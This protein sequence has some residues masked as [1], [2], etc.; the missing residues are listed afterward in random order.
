MPVSDIALGSHTAA[1]PSAD[2]GAWR[3]Q[4]CAV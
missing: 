3:C 1:A 4:D 2:Q